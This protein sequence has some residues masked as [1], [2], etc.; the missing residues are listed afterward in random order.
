[1]VTG[2]RAPCFYIRHPHKIIF[3]V[4]PVQVMKTDSRILSFL[5]QLRES[6]KTIQY[7]TDEEAGKRFP[8]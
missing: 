1:Q 3:Q 8:S 4:F 7:L 2:L 6:R 5:P